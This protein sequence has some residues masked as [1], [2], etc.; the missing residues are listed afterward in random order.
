[1]ASL[2]PLKKN[3]NYSN[4]RGFET[5]RRGSSP[6]KMES[7]SSITAFKIKQLKSKKDSQEE[8]EAMVF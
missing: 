2:S 4:G 8:E 3:R 7:N 5:D 6:F 1:M